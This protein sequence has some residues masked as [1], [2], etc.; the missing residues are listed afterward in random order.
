MKQL[1]VLVA[2]MVIG[3]SVSAADSIVGRWVQDESE[4][5]VK[6]LSYYDFGS[7]G[8]MVQTLVITSA[9]PKMDINVS[10]KASYSYQ[11]GNIAF[12]C[13]PEDITVSKFYIE[14]ADQN[15]INAAIEQ[16][17]AE[18]SSKVFKLREVKVKGDK[19]TAVY[20][21]NKITLRRVK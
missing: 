9:S 11:S 18:M 15:M 20:E 5:G 12:K 7:D 2:I 17:K 19:M 8:K 6:I 14:G 10:G 4:H 1:M 21:G 13:E 16:Q 3:M